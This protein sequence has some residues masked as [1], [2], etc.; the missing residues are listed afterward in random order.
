MTLTDTLR[1]WIAGLF[2]RTLASLSTEPDRMEV[3]AW[4]ALVR[5]VVADDSLTRAEKARQIY[6]IIDSRRTA[7]LFIGGI[8]KAVKNYHRSNLPWSIKVALPVTFGA[9]FVV[10]GGGAGI[11]AMGGAVG[12][13]ALLLIFLGSAGLT[14]VIEAFLTKPESRNYIG[15]VMAMIA[16]DEALRHAAKLREAMAADPVEPQRMSMPDEAKALRETL[17]SMNPFDFERHVMSFFQDAGMLAW[18]TKQSND[19]GVDGFARHPQGLILVQC[20]RHGPDNPI[21]RPTVQQFKG[22]IEENQAWRGYLVTTSRFTA[23][24]VESAVKNEKIVLVDMDAL[25]QWHYGGFPAH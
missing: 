2:I 1:Q 3:L 10:G 20:K 25:A 14:S 22:V 12:L 21:G 23:D 15:V 17:L 7:R 18:V 9:A 4:L 11:A 6:R 8:V 24:A 16:R 13:P 19:A 5:E